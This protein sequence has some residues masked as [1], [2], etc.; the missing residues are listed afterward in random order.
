M[1]FF[2]IYFYAYQIE[3]KFIKSAI[4]EVQFAIFQ[5]ADYS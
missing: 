5:N 2:L 3:E 4:N 1:F